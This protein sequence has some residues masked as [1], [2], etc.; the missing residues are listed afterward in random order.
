MLISSLILSNTPASSASSQKQGLQ[1]TRFRY[2]GSNQAAV[3]SIIQILDGVPATRLVSFVVKAHVASSSKDNQ[4][5]FSTTR[6]LVTRKSIRSKS[7]FRYYGSLSK[8]RPPQVRLLLISLGAAVQQL[9]LPCRLEEISCSVRKIP[10]FT[11]AY[12]S[13]FRKLPRLLALLKVQKLTPKLRKTN[14]TGMK[15]SRGTKN[16]R[17]IRNPKT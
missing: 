9:R 17:T 15:P 7:P 2:Y 14:P 8:V 1:S 12:L 6:F 4:T 3:K 10:P 13:D 5:Y 11:Q 16:E